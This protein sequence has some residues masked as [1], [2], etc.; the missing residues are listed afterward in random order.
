[1]N[2]PILTGVVVLTALF[3]FAS[4]AGALPVLSIQSAS[5][6]THTQYPVV[7]VQAVDP[8]LQ[9]QQLEETIRMLNGKVEDMSFQLLQMQ[10]QMRKTQEDNEFRFQELEKGKAGGKSG[11]LEKPV[12]DP[13]TKQAEAP[14]GKTSESPSKTAS[15]SGDTTPAAGQLGAIK[16]DANG[17]QVGATASAAP[18]ANATGK[19]AAAGNLNNPDD[20]Y[21]AAY[22]HVLS[23]DYKL[24]EQEFRDYLD[25]YPKSEKAADANFWLGESQYSLG[26]YNDAA[27]TFVSAHKAYPN[28]PKAPEILLK[29][30]MSLAALDN[31]DMACATLREVGK[32]YPKA[33]KPV[34][35]KVTSE[36][37]QLAC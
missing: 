15:S 29:L 16:L 28:A 37:S 25:I 9:I 4:G 31:K 30:G 12:T 3:G 24:A 2:R 36:M 13:S 32:Q 26:K 19:A 17:N 18:G 6:N 1:M 27:K 22:G 14:A 23:G 10:E 34:K 35:T 5:S 11:S 33:S 7:R 20:V 21:Q 8:S